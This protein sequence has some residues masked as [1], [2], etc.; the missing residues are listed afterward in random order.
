[1][2]TIKIKNFMK[3]ERNSQKLPFSLKYSQMLTFD[4]TYLMEEMARA[5]I[6]WSDAA[7]RRGL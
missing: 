6:G 1:M 3:S 7:V 5:K 2:S 4:F